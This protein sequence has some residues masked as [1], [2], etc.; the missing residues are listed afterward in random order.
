MTTPLSGKIIIITAPSGSGKTT[1]ANYLLKQFQQ[2]SFSVSATTREARA[3][4]KHGEQYFFLSKNEFEKAIASN[5]FFEYEEVY[6]GQFYGTLQ[7]ELQRIWL[8]QKIA[9]FDIDVKGAYHVESRNKENVLSIY[10]KASNPEVLRERLIL[11]GTDTAENIDKR[12]QKANEELEYAKYFD[13]VISND[14]LELAQKIIAEI[15]SDF[16][17]APLKPSNE[18]Q[19]KI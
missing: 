6:P 5:Q 10:V 19:S 18:L 12:I 11:R 16:I 1:I 9:L 3:Y 13:Y 8:D 4:E 2:L 17:L 14:R 15:V 7:S